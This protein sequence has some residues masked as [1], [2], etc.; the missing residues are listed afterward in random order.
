MTELRCGKLSQVQDLDG[1]KTHLL[2]RDPGSEILVIEERAVS[3]GRAL[4]DRLDL[5]NIASG[6]GDA[7]DTRSLMT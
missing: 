6:V 5:A 1:P 7:A 4:R 2:A 3:N